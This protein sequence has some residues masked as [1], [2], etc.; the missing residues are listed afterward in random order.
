MEK[1]S[2]ALVLCLLAVSCAG[3]PAIPEL[4][5]GST[6]EAV[7]P[8]GSKVRIG[9]ADPR[10]DPKLWVEAEVPASLALFGIEATWLADRDG[11][12]APSA[13]EDWL[14]FGRRGGAATRII[15]WGDAEPLDH[16]AFDLVLVEVESSAGMATA[17]L[18]L[19]P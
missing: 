9:V 2:A 1:P 7:L 11:D 5:P 16:A 12:G 14:R 3:A 6:V 4:E 8:D 15:A 10:R 18:D 17:A 19:R 13:G